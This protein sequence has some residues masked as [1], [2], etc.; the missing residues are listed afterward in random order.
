MDSTGT[1][2]PVAAQSG[3]AKLVTESECLALLFTDDSRP[4]E[5][6]WRKWKK[7]RVFPFVKIGRVSLYDPEAV[8]AAITKSFTVSARG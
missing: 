4:A 6:T 1:T 8:R 5:R 2:Q 3:T 7:R